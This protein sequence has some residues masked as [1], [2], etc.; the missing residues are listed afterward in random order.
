M[1]WKRASLKILDNYDVNIVITYPLISFHR[2]IDVP[3]SPSSPS[4]ATHPFSIQLLH[5][6]GDGD[7]FSCMFF[8]L[9]FFRPQIIFYYRK[10]GEGKKKGELILPFS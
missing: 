4:P 6:D 2:P 5:R 7:K 8:F 1:T 10:T 3:V 9:T